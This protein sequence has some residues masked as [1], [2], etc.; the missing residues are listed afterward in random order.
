MVQRRE[1]LKKRLLQ[2]Q[3]ELIEL[4]GV[5]SVAGAGASGSGDTVEA[6]LGEEREELESLEEEEGLCSP[7]S[8]RQT[9]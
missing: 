5:E 7:P 1:R 6:D 9:R 4:E 2:A 8:V 3:R